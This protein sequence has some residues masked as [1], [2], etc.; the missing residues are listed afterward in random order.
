MSL[1]D[2]D[3]SNLPELTPISSNQHIKKSV[4][5]SAIITVDSSV[6]IS[7]KTLTE[8]QATMSSN[9]DKLTNTFCDQLTN[10]TYILKHDVNVEQTSKGTS[11]I[12]SQE[13][14]VVKTWQKETLKK[15][16]YE[17]CSSEDSDDSD[18]N[19]TPTHKKPRV[20]SHYSCVQSS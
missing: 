8:Q 11:L 18:G 10:L 13:K 6:N 20:N 14:S 5:N 17:V 16:H 19:D 4:Q 9:I 2:D 3:T 1:Q 15:H 12:S 7:L